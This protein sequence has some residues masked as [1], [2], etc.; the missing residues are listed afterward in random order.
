MPVDDKASAHRAVECLVR[1]IRVE[2]A[3]LPVF[4]IDTFMWGLLLADHS[5]EAELLQRCCQDGKVIV[6][7]T[8]ALEAELQ[9]RNFLTG[10]RALAGN[11]L[12]SVPLGRISANQSIQALVRYLEKREGL[13]LNWHLMISEPVGLDADTVGLKGR[14]AGLVREMNGARAQCSADSETLIPVIADLERTV[15]RGL[16]RHYANLLA[17]HYSDFWASSMAPEARSYD[18]FFYTDYFSDLPFVVLKAYF[19]A[20]ILSERD[21]KTQDIIDV[22]CIAELLPYC[23]LFILD[24]DQHNRF[25]GLLRRYPQVFAR[26]DDMCCLSSSL[27]SAGREPEVTLRA[28]LESATAS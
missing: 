11:A 5:Q 22:H 4:F 6:V 13:D 17:P 12:L 16:L 15:S 23:S 26:L 18:R 21:I 3:S 8:N 28:F 14:L 7:V 19:Y 1:R 2:K 20:S 24:S 27:K 10:A 25:R 9:Q